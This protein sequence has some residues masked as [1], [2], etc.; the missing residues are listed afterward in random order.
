MAQIYGGSLPAAKFGHMQNF[1]DCVKRGQQ[2]IGKVSDHV[3]S[4]NAAHLANI[5][6]LLGRKVRWDI[7]RQQFLDDAEANLLIHRKQRAPYTIEI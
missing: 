4:V 6:L 3:R 2:P 7:D 5:S 1:F